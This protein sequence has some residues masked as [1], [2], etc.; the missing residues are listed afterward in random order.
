[1]KAQDY[2]D[3]KTRKDFEMEAQSKKEIWILGL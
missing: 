2:V 1:M 3:E